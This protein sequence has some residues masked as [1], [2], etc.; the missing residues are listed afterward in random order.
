[1]IVTLSLLGR[2]DTAVHIVLGYR[3]SSILTL[4][5]IAKLG[6]VMDWMGQCLTSFLTNSER[7]VRAKLKGSL[8][9]RGISCIIRVA[10]L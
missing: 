7:S 5:G 9:M 2:P 6:S 1:M 8:S 3:A 10:K 4:N